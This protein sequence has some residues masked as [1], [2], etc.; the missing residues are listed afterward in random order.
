MF[1]LTESKFRSYIK[2]AVKSCL[3][4]S[5]MEELSDRWDHIIEVLGPEKFLEDIFAQLSDIELEDIISYTER[6]WDIDLDYEE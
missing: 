3:K 6:M 1:K 4:E 2:E 5:T